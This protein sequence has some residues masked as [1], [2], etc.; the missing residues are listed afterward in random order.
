MAPFYFRYYPT[1]AMFKCKHNRCRSRSRARV[2]V[3]EGYWGSNIFSFQCV[4][5]ALL[6]NLERD[7]PRS[8]KP[9]LNL[10]FMVQSRIKSVVLML[11]AYQFSP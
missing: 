7:G 11:M 3:S 6:C 8:D 2:E 4:S 10:L 1:H 5:I 9:T